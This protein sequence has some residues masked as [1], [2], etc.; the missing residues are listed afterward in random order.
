MPYISKEK[1]RQYKYPNPNI[2]TIEI[3]KTFTL[4]QA[5][6]WLKQHGFL[7]KNYRRTTNY[8]RFIQNDVIK[9]AE[10]YSK[11]LPNGVIIVSQKY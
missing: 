11:K 5:R 10:Y 2:Q 3:P 8:M 6:T 1:A 7:Y 4:S 9:G